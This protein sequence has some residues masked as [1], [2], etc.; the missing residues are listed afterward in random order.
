MA[1]TREQLLQ[2][3]AAC[4]VFQARA[5]AALETWGIRAPPPISTELPGYAEAYR[6]ELA[7]M[8]K[9]RL[10]EDH[11]LRKVDVVHSMHLRSLSHRYM[12]P[13]KRLERALTA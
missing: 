1:M 5:D 9:K 4:R 11:E 13:A 2:Q 7:Y 6:R 12:R 10:P 8:A 3:D